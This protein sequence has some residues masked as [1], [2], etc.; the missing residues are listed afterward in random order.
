[1]RLRTP[2]SMMQ[3]S[4]IAISTLRLWENSDAA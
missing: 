2:F 1:M 3:F 4:L